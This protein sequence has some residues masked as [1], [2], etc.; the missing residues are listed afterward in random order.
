MK[1]C[2]ISTKYPGKDGIPYAFVEQLVNA[3][4]FHGHECTVIAP[5]H[6]VDLKRNHI[7]AQEYEERPVGNSIVRIFRPRYY[8][9]HIDIFGV[10]T[11]QW[12]ARIVLERTIRKNKLVFDCFYCHFF[13]N[14]QVAWKYAYKNDIPLFVATGE[15]TIKPHMPRPSFSFSWKKF[16]ERTN[17]VICV[18][19][20]NL[21]ECVSLKYADREKCRVF[22]NGVSASFRPIN[23]RE[24][25]AELGFPIDKFIVVCVGS[26]VNRKGQMRVI[27]AL[28]QLNNNSINAI[29]VGSGDEI[30]HRDYILYRGA[31]AHEKLPL[32]LNAA[33]LFVLPTLKEGCCNAIV[34]ALACNLPVISSNR[35]FNWDMLN[36]NNSILINPEN[37]DEIAEAI[38][39]LYEDSTKRQALIANNETKDYSIERRAKNILAFMIDSINN[40]L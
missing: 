28:D 14:A 3:F 38:E 36:K 31:V 33:D 16:R 24:C 2:I 27:K 29:F 30:E 32:Y 1:I 26:F 8:L 18:S 19:T 25:R 40:G 13:V 6:I 39:T 35:N 4:V 20:K 7:D 34:E 9:R 17:G 15:S 11:T 22:P 23:K 10:S 21:E 37:V 5:I 12:N